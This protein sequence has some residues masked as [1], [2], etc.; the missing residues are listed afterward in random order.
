MRE[1][2]PVEGSL[3]ALLACLRNAQVSLEAAHVAIADLKAR[4]TPAREAPA[5]TAPKDEPDPWPGPRVRAVRTALC[6]TQL[7]FAQRLGW[8]GAGVFVEISKIENGHRRLPSRYHPIVEQ[9]EQEAR[10]KFATPAL[11][12]TMAE[13]VRPKAPVL[14]N[15]VAAPK[16]P[17]PK[18]Q[19]RPPT[20][21]SSQGIRVKEA[22][23]CERRRGGEILRQCPAHAAGKIYRPAPPRTEPRPARTPTVPLPRGGGPGQRPCRCTHILKDHAQLSGRCWVCGTGA[24]RGCQ[25]FTPTAVGTNATAP[26]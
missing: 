19:G 12:P 4:L 8:R 25:R 7:R 22:C 13:P 18:D 3:V 24:G 1:V 5:P 20:I 26:A 14:T 6:L 21:E 17:E 10:T 23:G 11:P 9:L 2:P 15:R 16:P